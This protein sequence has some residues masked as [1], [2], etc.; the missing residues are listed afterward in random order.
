MKGA[1]RACADMAFDARR[2]TPTVRAT[3]VARTVPPM[4]NQLRFEK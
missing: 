3:P 2:A 4:A 1:W